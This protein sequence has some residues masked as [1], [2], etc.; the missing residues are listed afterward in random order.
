MS[1]PSTAADDAK[2]VPTSTSTPG[3]ESGKL[4]PSPGL[5][6]PKIASPTSTGDPITSLSDY[7]RKTPST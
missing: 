6:R 1:K 5:N 3:K 7:V 2:K 4:T